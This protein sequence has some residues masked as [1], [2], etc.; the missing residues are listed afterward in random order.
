MTC[1]VKLRIAVVSMEQWAT[2][3]GR[4][5]QQRPQQVVYDPSRPVSVLFIVK[6]ARFRLFR[7]LADGRTVTTAM[8]GPGSVFGEMDLL[9]RRMVGTRAEA[10][11]AGDLCLMSR[12]DVQGLLLGDPRI[13][14][15]V[16]EQIGARI[17]ELEQRLTEVVGKSLLERIAHAH[18]RCSCRLSSRRRR[19]RVGAADPRSAGRAGRRDPRARHH[20]SRR[21]RRARAG[22]AASGKDQHPRHPRAGR[23][24]RQWRTPVPRTVVD[25]AAPHAAPELDGF[26]AMLPATVDIRAHAIQGR[27]TRPAGFDPGPGVPL[28]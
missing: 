26:A 5:D 19:T 18:P 2:E 20:G 25:P 15:R 23:P 24:V 10:I 14:T 16:A 12:S 6:T 21:A 22:L 9:G 28:G 4:H 17:A 7:V 1:P 3:A 27:A 8:P 13:E 11:E